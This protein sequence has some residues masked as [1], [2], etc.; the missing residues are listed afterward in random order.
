MFKLF[1]R[2]PPDPIPEVL[3]DEIDSGDGWSE[4]GCTDARRQILS[5]IE[6]INAELGRMREGKE[7]LSKQVLDIQR[8]LEDTVDVSMIVEGLIGQRFDVIDQQ[9]GQVF[10]FI[11]KTGEEES[12]T[13]ERS[14]GELRTW[15]EARFSK[16]AR[17]VE[18]QFVKLDQSV[19]DVVVEANQFHV[20]MKLEMERVHTELSECRQLVNSLMKS[21]VGY[22]QDVSAHRQ[23]IDTKLDIFK[24]DVSQL[25]SGLA[26][27]KSEHEKLSSRSALMATKLHTLAASFETTCLS[28]PSHSLSEKSCECSTSLRKLSNDLWE[29]TVLRNQRFS[30]VHER[31]S[32]E[33][34]GIRCLIEEKESTGARL[35]ESVETCV[36]RVSLVENELA[37]LSDRCGDEVAERVRAVE[38]LRICLHDLTQRVD[39]VQFPS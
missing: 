33:L 17:P 23:Q 35:Q 25:K 37:S 15:V 38:E 39:R 20:A 36:E 5:S 3:D 29:E 6:A 12:H 34:A 7:T 19:R 10:T 16:H 27:V 2:T 26:P 4:F 1:G 18:E 22:T 8:T 30:E 13:R 32:R 14:F 21:H 24:N 9:F 28:A 31:L 11:N